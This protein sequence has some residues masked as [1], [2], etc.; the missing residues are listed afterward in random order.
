MNRFFSIA[1]LLL[2]AALSFG[3]VE[4]SFEA[5]YESISGSEMSVKF[6]LD[7]IGIRE[8]VKDGVTYSVLDYQG[9]KTNEK[10]YAELP[11]MSAALQLGD[12]YDV[13]ISSVDGNY[14][15]IALDHPLLP[16]RG[17]IYR[18]QDPSTIPYEIDPKSVVDAWYPENAAFAIDP[19]VFRDVRGINI[20][21]HPVQYN[22][23]KQTIR[24]YKEMTV[25]LKED[26]SKT[27]N[28]LT[29][30]PDYIVSSMN[31]V[32]RSMFINYDETKF[33]HQIGEFGEMLVIYT[34][35]DA[36]VIQPYIEWKRQKG[37][38]VTTSQVAT[39]TNVKTTVA[40][41]YSSNPNILYVQLVGD[42]ADIKC[43][44]GGGDN[45]PMDPMLGDI[46]GSDS[47]PELIVGRFSANSTADVTVQVD[48]AINYEKNPD[49]AGTWYRTGLG[50]GSPDGSGIGDDGE[51]DYAHIDII[52]EN[53]LL[54]Y[55]YTTVNEAYSNPTAT[56]VA[57]YV[58]A[59]LG[60]IN[61]CGHGANTYWVTSSYS[62]TNI[63]SST[64][65]SKL[66]FIISV[67]C[68]NGEFDVTTCFAEAWLR[69]SGGGA[70]ATLMATIN[71]PW[72]QPQ[73]AQDYMNDI[74]VGGYNYSTLPGDADY[75]PIASDKRTTFG[76]ITMNGN[77]LMLT[78][79]GTSSAF[80]TIE[81]WTIFGDAS[82]QVR[83]DTPKALTVSNTSVTVGTP[84]T[85]NVKAAGANFQ[86]ALVSLYQ[87]GNTFS[88]FTDTSGNVTI[89]Q[90][91]VAGTAKLTVTGYNTGTTFQ[92]V[93]VSTGSTP[94]PTPTLSSPANGSG[95]T[96]QT[97]T[98][99]WSNV[100]GT[101]YTIQVDN[102]SGFTS[103]EINQTVSAV[104]YT[105]GSN[106]ALGTYYWRVL[107]TNSYGSSSYSSAWSFTIGAAPGAPTLASPA[108]GSSTGDMTPT[109]DWS[110]VSGAT[111]YTILVDNNSNFS[112]P[113]I[114]QSPATST[115][116]P[117][118]N[119]NYGT[120]YWKVLANNSYG[121]GAYSATWTVNIVE[122]AVTLPL[123]ENFNA[124]TTVP[125]GWKVVDNQGNGQVWQFGTHTSGLSGAD[126]NY[127]YLNSD[128]YGSGSS[129]NSDLVTPL[130]D[131]TGSS[132]ITVEFKHY[133]NWYSSADTA[134]LSYSINGGTSWVQ[135]QQWTADITNPTTFSQVITAVANQPQVK[136]KWNY[137]GSYGYYW[138]VDDI[139]IETAT[140]D[141]SPIATTVAA[142]SVGMDVATLNGTVNANGYSTT[143]TFEYGLTTGYGSTMAGTP[144]TVTGTTNT[145][146]SANL[147][148][149]ASS[150]TYN[151]RVKAV[152]SEGTTYGANQ[153]FTTDAEPVLPDPP[154]DLAAVVNADDV[155]LSWVAP[156]SGPEP[157][158]FTDGFEAYADFALTF[159]N[160]TQID[161]DG[162]TAYGSSDADFTNEAYVGSYIIFNPSQTT[163]ALTGAWAPHTGSKYAA[164]F[165]VV[166]A[167]A[168]NNDWMITPQL[169]LGSSYSFS[170]YAKSVKMDWGGDR[171]KVGVS[172]TGTA[173]G[174]FTIISAGEYV[175]AT[176]TWTNYSYDLSAYAGQTVYLAIVCVSNDTFVLAIDDVNVNNAKGQA[177][178]AQNFEN[179]PT[180]KTDNRSYGR[181]TYTGK[182][183]PRADLD[184][185]PSTARGTLG[186]YK[187][188]RNGSSIAT[189]SNPATLTY[190]DIG[191]SNGDYSYYVT[192]TYTDPTEESGPSNV[193]EVNVS[194][195]VVPGTP[196]NVV[197][198]IDGTNLVIDWDV[199]TN[200]DSYDVYSSADPYGTFSFESNV[201]TNKY[202]V[203]YTA[204]KKFY[205]IVSK[206]GTKEATATIK[207]KKADVK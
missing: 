33:T 27:T 121:P 58:N 109:F 9:V 141:Y 78:E 169:L 162:G 52:K 139:S 168:P 54:P 99:E 70:V 156:V 8:V 120:Y 4:R 84:F 39:G 72:T 11:K 92:D 96:D 53:K 79:D 63:A 30:K 65:G 57:N 100:G 136:F 173:Q 77:V 7:G 184:N 47:Y 56:T 196:S 197:T 67:A 112:S 91:L 64:N 165:S 82:L 71:Q 149:L 5:K 83:T 189:I 10:G 179:L 199:A 154:T 127:A 195:S 201:G 126:G 204:A 107:A 6:T 98:F 164:C 122:S 163:P 171:F 181:S 108:N 182:D 143:V 59:G 66:P 132:D 3:A 183:V 28:P 90:T 144:G 62:N 18:N 49:M 117:S 145:S 118:T 113:E 157:D 175:T 180:E 94:P 166:A 125:A 198:S 133:F 17:T 40:N 123:Y 176:G 85:T 190:S 104:T 177:V 158:T 76:A 41:A 102:G 152:N 35:R 129:Q 55:T 24:V 87:N 81:T 16:S 119:L 12:E 60:I 174:D 193:E 31:D 37:F 25:V 19:Y 186:G 68:V 88:G 200:A 206:S 73:V 23:A 36:T 80:D 170:F 140:P 69:K 146:V 147:T 172:T 51:I 131:A 42:W 29:I 142:T 114:S 188:Y 21:A 101:S 116:T 13:V 105:P 32:Y 137:T 124:G 38:K 151:F 115:Y 110:D 153:T 161:G 43:D 135:I 134:T 130:I 44:L 14:E 191:L 2:V 26:L 1:A 150:S 95:T 74:L 20:Y 167:D 160:W 15:E 86:N 205:Y 155:S 103:P 192:A 203:S 97:P 185:Q 202:I 50:I 159:A 187:V 45:S 75:S 207:L 93:T 178:Y 61:Y 22:A 148:G 194:V 111:S 48:K 89:P 106:L 128:A 34:S 46:S 138:D